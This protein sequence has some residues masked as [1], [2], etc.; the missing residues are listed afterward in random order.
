MSS[1]SLPI[2][3]SPHFSNIFDDILTSTGS[4]SCIDINPNLSVLIS[5]INGILLPVIMK[6]IHFP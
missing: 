5:L 6:T 4:M 2:G 3:T 1:M